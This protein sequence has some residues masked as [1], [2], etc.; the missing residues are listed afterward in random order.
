MKKSWMKLCVCAALA[1]LAALAAHSG[2]RVNSAQASVGIKRY[3]IASGMV[4]YTLSGA[5]NGTEILYFTDYGMRE[6]KYSHTEIKVGTFTQKTNRVTIL[7]GAT[8]YTI[9]LDNNTG[10][11]IENPF[12]KKF[13][14]QDATEVGE[15]ML[16]DMGGQKIGTESFL[17][18]MCEV[19]EIQKLG[20]KMWVWSG[21]PLKNETRFAGM[22]S[23][24][25]ATKLEPNAQ[26]PPA[27]LALP[28]GAKISAGFDLNKL[29]KTPTKKAQE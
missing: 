20:S 17:G 7:E 10:T 25:V 16:R 4:E 18:K 3:Q 1:T 22:Q 19:W 6:A 27:K 14:G 8:I 21:I 2:A 5:Q 9:D 11:K 28:P 12:Y 26:I 15:R 29:R 24:V 13:E 23:F